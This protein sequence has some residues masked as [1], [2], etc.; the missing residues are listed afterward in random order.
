M[1]VLIALSKMVS[2]ID[3]AP[4]LERIK[5]PALGLYPTGGRRTGPQEEQIQ[6]SI[7]GI[8]FVKMPTEYHAI[9]SQNIRPF[10]RP[11]PRSAIS[12]TTAI[13]FHTRSYPTTRRSSRAR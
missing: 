2:K 10:G 13:A 1:D 5:T 9:Q 8:R 11:R 12:Q 3:I 6:R 4:Y 7:R